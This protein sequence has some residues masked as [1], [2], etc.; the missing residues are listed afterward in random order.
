MP[1]SASRGGE[2]FRPG[3]EALGLHRQKTAKLGRLDRLHYGSG[4]DICG[5]TPEEVRFGQKHL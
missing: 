5:V 2:A 1:L 4:I 3:D